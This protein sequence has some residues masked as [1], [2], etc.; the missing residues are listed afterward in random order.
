MALHELFSKILKVPASVLTDETG[1]K[2]LSEW[3]S[4][5]HIEL[6]LSVETEYNVRFSAAE[7]TSIYTIGNVRELLVQKGVSAAG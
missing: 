4:L 7:I 2:E 1:P 5:H 6:V 3:D